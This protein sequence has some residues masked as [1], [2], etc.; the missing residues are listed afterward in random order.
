[1]MQGPGGG[2]MMG[3]AAGQAR[4]SS[5]DAN[6]D[7]T[8][9]AD[10]AAANADLVFTAMDADE[11]GNLTVEE[12]MAVRMG[13]QEG[14]NPEREAS[15]QASK[16]ERFAAM[17]TDADDVVAKAEFMAAGEAHFNAAD[18]DGDGKVT[19]WEIRRS[20]WH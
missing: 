19:P 5:I 13:P 4:F 17:D 15:R 3:S 8:V 10:E 11:D 7:G 16:A 1:M 12:Y 14:L 2:M 6:E 20:N 18:S 9:S